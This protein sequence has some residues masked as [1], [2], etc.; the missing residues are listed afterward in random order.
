MDGITAHGAGDAIAYPNHIHSIGIVIAP[1]RYRNMQAKPRGWTGSPKATQCISIMPDGTR[2]VFVPKNTKNTNVAG[3][4]RRSSPKVDTRIAVD[5]AL[6]A[7]MG[8]I[9]S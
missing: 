4:V 3:I 5:Q 1:R 6:M 9:H 8:S 7:N 2:S